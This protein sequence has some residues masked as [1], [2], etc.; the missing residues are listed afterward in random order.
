MIGLVLGLLVGQLLSTW[1]DNNMRPV[2][3]R[4]AVTVVVVLLSSVRP[5]SGHAAMTG[6]DQSLCLLPV[7]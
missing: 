4:P 7:I 3:D 1:Y 5:P 6:T 2:Q